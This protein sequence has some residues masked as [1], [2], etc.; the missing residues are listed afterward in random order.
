M[1]E[2]M[3]SPREEL[4][5]HIGEC[6]QCKAANR[7][8]NAFCEIGI[9]LFAAWNPEPVSAEERNLSQE[10]FTKLSNDGVNRPRTMN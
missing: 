6:Q 3:Q 5:A 1:A 7:Y 2:S 10:E 4:L 8:V 9:A